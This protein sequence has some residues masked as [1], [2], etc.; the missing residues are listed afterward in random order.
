VAAV[1]SSQL[2][3]DLCE[4]WPVTIF[5]WPQWLGA[6]ERGRPI[7]TGNTHL[8]TAFGHPIDVELSTPS[9]AMP[10]RQAG[11]VGRCD[12]LAAMARADQQFALAERV[13]LLGGDCATDLTP[14]ANANRRARGTLQVIYFDAH[15]DIQVPEE[16]A[17]GA[18]HGMVLGHL[19]GRGD[20][21]ILRILRDP[22]RPDQI[23]YRGV[24]VFDDY[25]HQQVELLGI[26]IQP[27]DETPPDGALY[28][29]IDLDVLDPTSFPFTT[30]PTDNGPT[31]VEL[32]QAVGCL[33]ETG[34]VIGIAVTE[35][36]TP[37][38]RDAQLL[39]PL[40][41]VLRHWHTTAHEF[42]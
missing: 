11:I 29:H 16:S 4:T 1:T 9:P 32:A 23:H 7:A 38:L 22:L 20:R 28:L 19:L 41:A 12:L 5:A 34:R 27:I 8:V 25:E 13:L 42:V 18:L 30:W 35:C 31:I 14:I 6:T 15:A 36:A 26:D 10:T 24:R 33:V 40:L 3:G 17:S 39:E 37:T 21:D 2:F